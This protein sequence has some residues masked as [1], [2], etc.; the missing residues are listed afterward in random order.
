MSITERANQIFGNKQ[1]V[2]GHTDERKAGVI[3]TMKEFYDPNI[4][5]YQPD[6]EPKFGIDAVVEAEYEFF[7]TVKEL[8]DMEVFEVVTDDHGDHGTTFYHYRYN[9]INTDNQEEKFDSVGKMTWKNDK[10]V[11]ERVYWYHDV[12]GVRTV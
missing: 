10:I 3:E 7:D 1:P 12:D 8:L 6:H 2:S 4:A 5:K 11:E 9:L